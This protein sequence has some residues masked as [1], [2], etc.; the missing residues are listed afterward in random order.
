MACAAASVC[1]P[2]SRFWGAAHT[3]L[4]SQFSACRWALVF[5]RFVRAC[6]RARECPGSV[7]DRGAARQA[8]GRRRL[9]DELDAAEERWAAPRQATP[10]TPI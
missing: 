4:T 5:V 8:V 3:A 2:V 7:G 1:M 10:P 6:V 9:E